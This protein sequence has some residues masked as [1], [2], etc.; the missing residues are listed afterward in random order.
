MPVGQGVGGLDVGPERGELLIGR[1]EGG[2]VVVEYIE[3]LEADLVYS[4]PGGQG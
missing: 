2:L 1:L 4:R 3:R